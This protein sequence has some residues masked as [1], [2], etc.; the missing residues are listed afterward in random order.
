M[1]KLI[2]MQ[3]QQHTLQATRDTHER[4]WWVAQEVCEILGLGNVTQA[5]AR[6]RDDEPAPANCLPCA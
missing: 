1:P 3:F 2:R 4:V 6:L 5:M